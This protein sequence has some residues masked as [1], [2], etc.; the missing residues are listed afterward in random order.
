MCTGFIDADLDREF[1]GSIVQAKDK[2]GIF[3]Y[4]FGTYIVAMIAT[5]Y[6]VYNDLL[7]NVGMAIPVLLVFSLLFNRYHFQREFFVLIALYLWILLGSLM[8]EYR[9]LSLL[10]AVYFWKVQ[11]VMLVVALRCNSFRRMRFYVATLAIG[12]AFLVVPSLFSATY[13]EYDKR[14][15]G[16]VGQA[17]ALANITASSIVAWVCLLFIFRGRWKWVVFPLMAIVSFR[18]LLLSGSR[19]GFV[20]AMF[21]IAAVSWYMWRQGGLTKKV[22]FLVVFVILAIVLLFFAKEL[23]IIRR[24]AAIPVALGFKSDIEVT[25]GLESAIARMEI[26]REALKVFSR[27]PILGAGS[28]TFR[29]YSGYVYTHTTPFEFL[30]ATGI[31]G[32]LFYYFV[33]VSGWFVLAKAKKLGRYNPDIVKNITICQILIIVQLAAGLSIPTEGSKTQAILSGVWL[34]IVWYMRSWTKEQLGY[35]YSDEADFEL[36]EEV[37][38]VLT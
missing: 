21:L 15:A 23:P 1:N 29:M 3:D 12:S 19:G 36:A 31:V 13:L 18:V 32:T 11:F 9:L 35:Q 2:L 33:I 34:G 14:L 4:L 25:G 17:N 16:T 28:G 22:L 6:S 10:S 30:Y 7:S 37:E 27:H 20:T 5:N 38:G 8:S 26:I 24:F